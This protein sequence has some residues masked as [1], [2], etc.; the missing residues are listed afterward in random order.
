MTE[1]LRAHASTVLLALALGLVG[2]LLA[3]GPGFAGLTEALPG[4]E[5]DDSRN[6]VY[7]HH[8]VHEALMDGRLDLSDP[9][10]FFPTG[11]PLLQLHGGNIL[12]FIVS[13]I[14]RS[15]LPWPLWL[16][17]A[18]LAWIPLNLMAFVP[19]GLR[20]WER[21]GPALAA[22]T[23]WAMLPVLTG[24]I[25]AGRL[26]QVALIGLPIAV[27]GL[28]DVAE[29]GGRRAWLLAGVGMAL[30]GMGYW[31]HAQFLV[32]LTP[33]FAWRAVRTRGLRPASL[34]LGSAAVVTLLLVSP[35][36]LAVAWPRVMGTWT[37]QPPMTAEFMSPVFADALQLSGSQPRGLQGWLPG[38]VAVGALL[39]LW[40]GHR[41]ALWLS[42]A[43]VCTIFAL[44][45]AQ[46]IGGTR[47]LLPSFPLWR[48]VPGFDRMLHPDRWLEVGGL[49]FV[50]LAGE[51]LARLP[52]R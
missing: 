44:G 22:A 26:T 18:A 5:N 42:C 1:Q 33:F 13:G 17:V 9:H 43:L 8:Q 46:D 35:W 50:L 19:L 7:L 36:M 29:R 31:F 37:P 2:A 45:P 6:A 39:G 24:Q 30:T 52:G 28:L 25:A 12:E 47:W 23:A 38:V 15:L 16:S 20:L 4:Y 3:A 34:D 21:R 32:L 51:G 40:R 14:A 10:Q 11:T 27:L 41:R 48:W 49:F